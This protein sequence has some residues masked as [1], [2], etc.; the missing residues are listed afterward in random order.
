MSAPLLSV[1]DLRVSAGPL[2]LVDGISFDLGQGEILGLVGES[3]SGKTMA[4]RALMRLLPSRQVAVTGGRILLGDDDLAALPEADMRRLRG[5]ALGMVFQNPASHLDPVMRIGDQIAEGL[6]LHR[7]LDRKAAWAAAIDLLAQVG[8]PDPARRA[9]N[10]PHEFS[11]GMRQRAMIAVALSCDP[12]IL[13]AD[14]PTTA[15]D[16]TVQAQILRLLLALR[17]ARGLAIVLISHDL[18]VIAQTCDRI[19]VMYAGRIVE[20]GAKTDILRR[21]LHPYTQGLIRC[22]PGE[23]GGGPGL[24]LPTIAGQPPSAGEMPAGC[25]F[26]PRCP[27]ASETCRREMPAP[28]ALEGRIVACHHPLTGEVP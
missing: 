13:I 28:H 21:P 24:P 5:H 10:Y 8:I 23:D 25:R 9:R 11:G 26:H 3:G 15:L 12:G 18:G 16:V 14:E 4:C 17:E 20:Q 19:A 2:D 7:G 27:R 6:R 1:R 22:Q